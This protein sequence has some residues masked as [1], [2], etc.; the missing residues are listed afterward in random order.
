[1]GEGGGG[2]GAILAAQEDNF[3]LCPILALTRGAPDPGGSGDGRGIVMGC[4]V[5]GMLL[6]SVRS[7]RVTDLN[8]EN[9]CYCCCSFT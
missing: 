3:S 2:G 5:H 7:P 8:A 4:W 1:M 9:E 6:H